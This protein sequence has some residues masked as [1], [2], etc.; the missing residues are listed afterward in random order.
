MFVVSH[1]LKIL[2]DLKKYFSVYPALV[3]AYT[4]STRSVQELSLV[5]LRISRTCY[6]LLYSHNNLSLPCI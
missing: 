6:V 1:I 4:G 3:G 2:K 5:G